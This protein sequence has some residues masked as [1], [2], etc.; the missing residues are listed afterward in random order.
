MKNERGS[1]FIEAVVALAI[2]SI[3][4]VGFL[5]ALATTSSTRLIADEHASA[6][7]IAE[8]QMEN[9]KKQT[10]AFS[11]DDIP[12]SADY[13]GYSATLD[14]DNLRNGNIQKITVTVRHHSKDITSLESYKVNR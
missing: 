1:S 13:A 7:I 11:Y 14:I 10:Y 6:R 5:A 2:L 4:G 3:I 12:V 9:I 8:S